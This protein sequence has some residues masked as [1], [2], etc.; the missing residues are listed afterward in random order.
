MTIL[1]AGGCGFIGL[2]LSERLLADGAKP[3]AVLASICKHQGALLEG[4]FDEALEAAGRKIYEI[5]DKIVRGQAVDDDKLHSLHRH[6]HDESAA[7]A[8]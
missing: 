8:L 7:C 1:I 2:A 6:R 5:I 4:D 3:A